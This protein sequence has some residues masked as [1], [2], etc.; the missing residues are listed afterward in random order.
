MFNVDLLL[1][2]L[3]RFSFFLERSPVH[4]DNYFHHSNCTWIVTAPVG[5]VVEI[6]SVQLNALGAFGAS[7]AYFYVS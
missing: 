4:P 3:D 2:T 1:K 7:R 6:K 5:K